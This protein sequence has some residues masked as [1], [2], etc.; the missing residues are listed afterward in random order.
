MSGKF[1]P[2]WSSFLFNLC[3]YTERKSELMMVMMPVFVVVVFYN[4]FGYE[5]QTCE[6]GLNTWKIKKEC[7]LHMTTCEFLGQ[8]LCQVTEQHLK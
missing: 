6:L 5:Y 3:A 7:L 1:E 2:T 4:V 8:P